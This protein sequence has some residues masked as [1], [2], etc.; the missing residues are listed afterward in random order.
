MRKIFISAAVI[1]TML[2]T[3]C[4]TGDTLLEQEPQGDVSSEQMAEVIQE[5]PERAL[6]ILS[7]AESGNK[8]YMHDFN[9]NGAGAHDDFGYMSVLLGLDHMTNDLVMVQND[10]VG[11]YYQYQARQVE[12]SRNRMVWN[13]EYKVIYHMNSILSSL[14]GDSDDVEERAL[15]GR[16]LAV[17]A[18]AYM[19]LIRTYAVGDQGIPYYSLGD[20]E[21]VHYDKMATSEVW[22]RIITSLEDAHELLSGYSGGTKE[23]VSGQVVAG[24]L[25]R[26]YMFRED[27]PKAAQYA[28]IARAG[29]SPM[30]FD[31]LPVF[32]EDEEPTPMQKRR[33]QGLF[34]GFQFISNSNWMWGAQI[35]GATSSVYASFFS[36]MDN[37][38]EGYAGQLNSYRT[39]DKRLYDRIPDTDVR[40]E[41]FLSEADAAEF[42]LPPFSHI[43]FRDNTFFEGDYIYMRADEFFLVE[44]EALAHTDEGAARALL[45]E[46][47]QTRN[48][49]FSADNLSGSDLLDEIRFQRRLELWGEGGEWWE[50]KRHGEDLERD[51]QETNHANFGKFNFPAESDRFYFQ[52]PQGELNGNPEISN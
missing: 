41:W 10:W 50:M 23:M 42:G 34:E 18:N 3:S 16:V 27:Y 11:S 51:Y 33:S 8:N 38:N 48:P 19:D 36:H 13:F 12:N 15:K 40:K 20:E 37:L 29:Y 31:D 47:V 9:S 14:V 22:D 21:I 46:F 28:N 44:A 7:G 24:M 26:A 49:D 25:A 43:K 35:T 2:F 30:G 39:V 5:F 52:I 1:A 32:D 4:D 6:T 17:R 45:N